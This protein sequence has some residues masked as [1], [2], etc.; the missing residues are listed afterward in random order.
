MLVAGVILTLL[1]LLRPA[2]GHATR[3]RRGVLVA[4]RLAVILLVVLA[5]LRPERTSTTLERKHSTLAVVFDQ[6]RS[7]RVPD[8]PG[9]KT[10]WQAQR[11]TLTEAAPILA[12]MGENVSVDLF[13]FDAAAHALDFSN[14][15]IPFA[16][17]PI[18]RATDIG[19]SLDDVLQRQIGKRL[20]GVI[21]LSDGAQRAY[22]PRVEMQQAARKLARLGCPLYT[23][24]FGLDVEKSQA[25]DVAVANLQDQYTIFVKNELAIDALLRVR[26]F[27][28]RQIAVELTVEDSSGK[29]EVVET[30]AVVAAE[31]VE[32]INV[33]MTYVPQQPGQ[34]RLTLRAAEQPG[35]LD[36]KN[37]QLTAFLTVLKG[38]LKVLFLAG[39][40]RTEQNFIRRALDASVDIQVDYRWIDH[41]RRDKW[42]VVDLQDV[43]ADP[44]Y[45]VF[46]LGDLDSKALGETNLD[47]IEKAV[48]RGAGLMMIGGYHSFGPGGYARTVLADVLPVRMARIGQSFDG[49]ILTEL[50]HT[51]ELRMRPAVDHFITHLAQGEENRAAWERLPALLGANKFDGLKNRAIVLAESDDG[52]PL[53]IAGEYGASGRVLAM[54]GDS[55]WRWHMQGNDAEHRRFWRQAIL[56]L[57]RKDELAR[58]DVW[59]ELRQRRFNPEARVTFTAGAKSS[60]GDVVRGATYRAKVISPDGGEEAVRLSPQGEMAV[61]SFDASKTAGQ[62]TIVVSATHDGHELGEAKAKFL[63]LDQDIELSDPSANPDQLDGQSRPTRRALGNH[64]RG[65]RPAA[66]S[67]RSGRTANGDQESSAGDGRGTRDSL[68]TRQDFG[69]RVEFLAF[70][71]RTVWHGM[72]FAEEMG[73]GVRRALSFEL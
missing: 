62:Y 66:G 64:Q 16:E 53:L 71:S 37:N 12:D 40:L 44:D 33:A 14:G 38:G 19:S 20:A 48:D 6:S 63:V 51:G 34:Y 25:R 52:V 4:L 61:G 58:K 72:V 35:E 1:L 73:I 54:A 26:G 47:L 68:A 60:D 70:V 29:E 21:L 13:A 42:P 55:T 11:E 31:D 3:W 28:G 67:R 46:L 10:R 27:A 15:E 59:I 2:F 57:V 22:A 69:Q 50:H 7:M 32:Q 39:E 18:G 9:G 5:M 56:W 36:T 65:G 8:A 30:Q 41:R 49:R 23:I 45:D 17:G 24:A 43:L